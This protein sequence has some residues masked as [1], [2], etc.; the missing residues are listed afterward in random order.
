MI[1]NPNPELHQSRIV[2]NRYCMQILLYVICDDLE[3]VSVWRAADVQRRLFLA[4]NTSGMV[5]W[6]AQKH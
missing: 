5:L 3:T 6:N 2:S 1:H 4:Q